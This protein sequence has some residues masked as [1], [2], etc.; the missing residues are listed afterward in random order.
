MPVTSLRRDIMFGQ[1]TYIYECTNPDKTMQTYWKDCNICK[2]AKCG[3]SKCRAPNEKW[4]EQGGA[5]KYEHCIESMPLIGGK[6]ACPV[7]GHNCP[8]GA[9]QVLEC[10]R[11]EC[12]S[13]S[14]NELP[15]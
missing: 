12:E 3:Y 7:Y 9:K 13:W 15:D 11:I 5:C 14:N 10:V 4:K 6:S 2:W 1:K 8:G